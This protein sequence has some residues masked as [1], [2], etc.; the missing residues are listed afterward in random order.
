MRSAAAK[1]RRRARRAAS[2]I[3]CSISSTGTGGCSSSACRR[4]TARRARDRTRRTRRGS[5]RDVRRAELAGVD[6]RVRERGPAR[7]SRRAPP[8][9]FRSSLHRRRRTPLAPA[10]TRAADA[11]MRAVAAVTRVEPREKVGQPLER[12]LGL[13][14]AAPGEIQ[15]LAV[16]RREQQIAHRRR[17]EASARRR[18]EW[19]R[20]CRATSTSSASSSTIRYSTCTQKRENSLPVAPSLCAISF[21]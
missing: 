1:S 19:C 17:A 5:P 20:C 2:S 7:R 8:A 6:R 16:V 14:Q 10:S 3:S 12:L 18:R 4:L 13:R 21:S 11:R 9:V 15:L